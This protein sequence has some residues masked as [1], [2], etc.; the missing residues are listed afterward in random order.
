MHN[1]PSPCDGRTILHLGA[2]RKY[3]PGA[4][5]V[6]LV[7]ATGPDIVHDLDV[8]PWPLPNDYFGEVRAFDVIEHLTDIVAVME[9]IHRVCRDGAIVKITVPH[10]SARNAFTDITHRHFF[11]VSSFDYF[12]GDNDLGFYTEC[13][14]RKLKAEI[15]FYPSLV[16]KVIW[17]LARRS[18][19]RYEQRYAWMFPAWFLSFELVVVKS[20][21]SG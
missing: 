12:T 2:G 13:R 7:A 3:D 20:G 10:Y 16:N 15:V 11:S 18:P 14:F 21:Q 17:R 1:I 4:V 19:V 8:R 5:N 6:D 9:E